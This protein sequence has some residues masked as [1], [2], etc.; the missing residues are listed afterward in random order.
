MHLSLDSE[1]NFVRIYTEIIHPLVH[2]WVIIFSI[3]YYQS[4]ENEY[5]NG[6]SGEKDAHVCVKERETEREMCLGKRSWNLG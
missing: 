5:E 2:S 6:H 1:K 3:D 4:L